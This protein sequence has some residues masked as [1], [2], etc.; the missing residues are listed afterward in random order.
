LSGKAYLLGR[1]E[2]SPYLIEKT[3]YSDSQQRS[4][5]RT[6]RPKACE[7]LETLS[8]GVVDLVTNQL[9]S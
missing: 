6:L 5:F 7:G 8:C 2:R 9:K 3:W 1:P 4:H